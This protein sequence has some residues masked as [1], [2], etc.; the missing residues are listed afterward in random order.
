MSDFW[1]AIRGIGT[2]GGLGSFA[3]AL[4]GF[5]VAGPPGALA[6]A[7]IGGAVGTQ[8]A[9][10]NKAE[11]ALDRAAE[12][13]EH[14]VDNFAKKCEKTVDCVGER[15]DR[16]ATRVETTAM[17]FIQD[18][19][20]FWS[21]LILAGYTFEMMA[22]HSRT[23]GLIQQEIC[24]NWNQDPGCISMS[25]TQVGLNSFTLAIGALMFW[26]VWKMLSL[27]ARMADKRAL[28]VQNANA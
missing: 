1:G 7:K 10:V 11:R 17:H 12:K 20:D 18:I 4:G 6:G 24:S 23:I 27:S 15:I 8:V 5:V 3:G 25:A 19:A 26:R 9:V 13:I 22:D 14:G 28:E 16:V 21:K 2:Y